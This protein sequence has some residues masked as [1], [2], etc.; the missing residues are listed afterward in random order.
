MNEFV[1]NEAYALANVLL[2]QILG[3][4]PGL[5]YTHPGRVKA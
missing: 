5:R 4:G 1:V 3:V 2:D